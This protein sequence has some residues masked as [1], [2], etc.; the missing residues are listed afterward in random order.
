MGYASPALSAFNAGEFSPEM[1][2]RTDIDKYQVASHIQQNFIATKQGPSTTRPGSA[3]VQPTKNSASRSWMVR[4]EFA[5]TQAYVLEFGDKYV[6]FYTNHGPLLST[7]NPAYS[8][9]TTYSPGDQVVS[10]GITYLCIATT[11]ANAPPNA[12]YWYPLAPYNG[13]A[14]VAIYE[15]P[16]PYAASD[17]TSAVGEFALQFEQSGDVLYIAGGYATPGPFGVGYPPYTLTRYANAPPKWLF[18]P[19]APTDGPFADELP[20]T[21]GQQ[22]ALYTDG[23]IGAGVSVHV[24]SFGGNAFAATDIGRLLRIASQYVT[25]PTWTGNVS[26]TAG[27]ICNNNG[28]N[29]LAL[30]TATSGV[31]PPTHTQGT[32]RDGPGTTGVQWQYLDSGYGVG[33]I[34][35]YV[36]PTEV[37]CQVLSAF[38]RDVAGIVKT[39]TNITQAPNPAITHTGGATYAAGQPLFVTGVAGMTQINGTMLSAAADATGAGPTTVTT[40]PLNSSNYGA[41]TSG[42][43]LLVNGTINWQ[44]GA[45]SDTSEWPR[46]AAFFKDRLFWGGRLNVWGSVPGAYASHTP[47]FNG[48][49]TTDSAINE[50][51]AGANGASLCWLS[52]ALVL[53]IGTEG[54]EFG[55]DS[56]TGGPLGPDNVEILKQSAWRCRHV[57]PLLIG[58]SVLYVQRS[59]RRVFAMDFN[60]Y[61][62]RYDSTDQTKYSHHITTGGITAVA[63]QQEP[64]S[65][66]WG[67]RADGTL[68]SYTYNREDN[69]TG[70]TR[71]NL[72]GNGIVE[73]I[74]CIPAPDGLRDELWMIVRRTI[75]GATVR[76][77]EYLTKPYEGPR[78][79]YAGDA[80]SSCWYLDAAAQLNQV[81]APG[82]TTTTI[83]GL[84]YLQGETVGILAD[85]GVQARQ[86]VPASGTITITG[87]YSVVT[88]GLPYQCNIVPMRPEGG[89]DFGTAQAKQKTGKIGH[90]RL[91][92]SGGGI[93]GQLTSSPNPL[94]LTNITL[95]TFEYIHY[96]ATT[97]ALDAPPPLQ[98]GDFQFTVPV[99]ATTE[100]DATDFYLIVQQNDPLPLTIAALY[101]NYQVQEWQK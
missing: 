59:G 61:L 74:A 39:I 33:L 44:L 89:A 23:S 58:P 8:G 18:A 87:A 101:P 60:F 76:S 48:L 70:W 3:W 52:P 54:G 62:N 34:T 31:N 71:H 4:F 98:S 28:N 90:I 80:Q 32:V 11:L 26:W 17:L 66:L 47:D 94:G 97:T 63:Y 38:P 88:V 77:V 50:L 9:A 84:Q 73:S 35:A 68:L 56:A 51:V 46:C 21:Q 45:W 82:A 55:L 99:V 72:G 65:V 95:P 81:P 6:R 37:I 49:V 93:I 41:Y 42:G 100:Q 29:Y 92:D 75:N 19:Y 40:T 2:G 85:G 5:Q 79:G 30:N 53:L 36:S 10:G 83:T 25:F 7:G 20:A 16:S 67:V 96:N 27:N 86:V 69:V 57:P 78:A 15:V 22:I 14:T 64:W 13:S 91:V 1:E 24:H 43:S 12:T